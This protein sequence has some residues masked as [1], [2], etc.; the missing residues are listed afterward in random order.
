M[1]MFEELIKVNKENNTVSA[2]ELHA[3]LESKERFSK[4]FNRML[5]YGFELGKDFA[6]VPKSTPVNNGGIQML[7]DYEITLDMAKEISM[8]QRTKKGKQARQYFIQCEKFIQDSK[9]TE[10]F[11]YYRETGKVARKNLTDT[12]K[13]ELQPSNNFVYRNYTELAYQ[14]AFGK[15]TKQLKEELHLGKKDNLRDNLDPNSLKEVLEAE[16]NI[17]GMIKTFTL[18][19]LDKK[20]IYSKIKEIILKQ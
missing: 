10:E 8:L 16:E 11:K 17:K 15:D 6:S 4:W 13:Q 3:F 7:E 12:I 18:M 1:K 5:G 2:R 19:K 14:L 9:L 20:E